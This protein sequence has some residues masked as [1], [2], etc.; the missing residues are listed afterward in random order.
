MTVSHIPQHIGL[1]HCNNFSVTAFDQ[2]GLN[3]HATHKKKIKFHPDQK[4]NLLEKME[5]TFSFLMEIGIFIFL[6][7]LILKF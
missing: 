5:D 4:Y 7:S 2:S 6:L 1:L 3:K